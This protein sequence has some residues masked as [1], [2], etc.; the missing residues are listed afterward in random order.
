MLAPKEASTIHSRKRLSDR[1][2]PVTVGCAAAAEA[3]CGRGAGR[4]GGSW[5]AIGRVVRLLI[6]VSL[7]VAGVV[8]A[9]ERGSGFYEKAAQWL[10]KT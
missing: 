6:D 10:T 9:R 1:A 7:L 5:T 3:G 4:S 2:N 8:V